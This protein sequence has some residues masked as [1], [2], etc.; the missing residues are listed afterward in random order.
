MLTSAFV[1]VLG[2]AVALFWAWQ[3]FTD[4]LVLAE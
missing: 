2:I 3:G 1:M 4:G